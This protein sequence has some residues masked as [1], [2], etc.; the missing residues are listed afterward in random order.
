ML[1]ESYPD[2]RE[3]L[4]DLGAVYRNLRRY[5]LAEPVLRRALAVDSLYWQPR[6]N[7]VWV[8]VGL[9]RRREAESTLQELT[10]G[11]RTTRWLSGWPRMCRPP[12]ATTRLPNPD[13]ER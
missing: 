3:A 7:L 11:F 5:D 2:D 9:G 1:L 4:N 10:G 6:F 8:L 12:A 13:C